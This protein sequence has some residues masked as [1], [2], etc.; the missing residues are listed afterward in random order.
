MDVNN[1]AP[2]CPECGGARFWYGRVEFWI[3][4]TSRRGNN[5]LNAAVCSECGYTSLYLQ[6][7][8]E[9]RKALA[10]LGIDPPAAN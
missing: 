1:P 9:F 4:G 7:M 3:D 10:K 2:P 6:N 5:D 8:P